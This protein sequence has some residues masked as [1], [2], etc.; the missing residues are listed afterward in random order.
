MGRATVRIDGLTKAKKLLD[1]E[2]LF[3]PEWGDAVRRATDYAEAQ[4]RQRIPQDTGAA[5]QTIV[6]SVQAKPV[7]MWGRVKF[8]VKDRPWRGGKFRTLYVLDASG[9]YKRSRG[10][11][12]TKG[13]LKNATTASHNNAI[14]EFEAAL[15]AI[16]RKAGK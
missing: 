2:F 3:Q 1:F 13:W 9:R 12:G 14:R 7:P 16:D 4:I 8:D 15:A 11:G 6:S 10:G 5:A